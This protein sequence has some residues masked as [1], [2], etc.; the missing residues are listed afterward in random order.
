LNTGPTGDTGPDILVA[1]INCPELRFTHDTTN[2]ETADL[3]PGANAGAK[4]ALIAQFERFTASLQ[5]Y[6]CSFFVRT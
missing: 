6:I 4:T 1:K 2:D 3:I 5:Y